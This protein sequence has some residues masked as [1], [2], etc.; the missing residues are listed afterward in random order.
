LAVNHCGTVPALPAAGTHASLHLTLRNAAGVQA[1]G[2]YTFTTAA[3][4]TGL[5]EELRRFNCALGHLKAID[6]QIP[7]NV[8]V[9]EL[10]IPPE[11]LTVIQVQVLQLLATVE[12]LAASVEKTKELSESPG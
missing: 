3:K 6:M 8:P 10:A 12:R 5:K 11:Q 9:E 2:S 4:R 1:E 7:P